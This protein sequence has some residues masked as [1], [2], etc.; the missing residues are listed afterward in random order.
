[1]DNGAG[2]CFLDN[3]FEAFVKN[4]MNLLHIFC[5][6]MTAFNFSSGGRVLRR[7]LTTDH[8]DRRRQDEG[9]ND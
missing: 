7:N 6:T 3:P 8:T 2:A 4:L 5:Y 9:T 1:V